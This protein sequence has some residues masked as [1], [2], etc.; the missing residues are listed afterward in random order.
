MTDIDQLRN[1]LVMANHVLAALG[2]ADGWGH[3]SV[4]VPDRP[5]RFL[6]AR[7]LAPAI[8]TPADLLEAEVATGETVNGERTYLERHIHSGIYR[9]RPEVNAVVHSHSTDLIP[10]TVTDTEL[11]PVLHASAFLGDG[12]P[13]FE[14]DG[15]PTGV[16]VE[17][18]AVGDALA[19]SLGTAPLV[20]MRAHGVSVVGASLRQAV[21]RSFYA[22]E[23]A[24]VL[25]KALALGAVSYTPKD[26]AREIAATVDTVI[27]RVWDLWVRTV[28]G[29]AV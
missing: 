4:R 23:N 10:F 19:A 21:Y 16:L 14:I 8:V 29:A 1:E 6:I 24:N 22:R 2:I 9:A 25:L 3:V 28:N 27:D 20:L 17:T 12:A 26:Q 13:R 18:S 11:L 5:D 15:Q 7:G